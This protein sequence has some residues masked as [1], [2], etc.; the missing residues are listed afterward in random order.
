M[1]NL[2]LVGQEPPTPDEAARTFSFR[3]A[4]MRWTVRADPV[5]AGSIERGIG[6]A[7][8]SA[9]RSLDQ[10]DQM[11]GPFRMPEPRDFPPS[12]A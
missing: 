1:A 4:E 6:E 2:R 9:Q 7:L 11:I 5:L 3:E 10:L 12:A 8:E